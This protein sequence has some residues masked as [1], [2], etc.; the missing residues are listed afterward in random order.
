MEVIVGMG[1]REYRTEGSGAL[2]FFFCDGLTW[3]NILNRYG[4]IVMQNRKT[5]LPSNTRYARFL[6]LF[7]PRLDVCTNC[8]TLAP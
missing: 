3:D 5:P 2:K 6:R 4:G 1:S 8:D 7:L